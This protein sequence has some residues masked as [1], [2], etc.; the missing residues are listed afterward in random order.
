MKKDL[1]DYTDGR[2][3]IYHHDDPQS[4]SQYGDS[5]Q[6]TFM[7]FISGMAKGVEPKNFQPLVEQAW[8]LINKD[9]PRRHWD[10]TFWPGRPGFMSRDNLFPAVCALTIVDSKERFKLLWKII[11]RGG[12]LWNTRKI[13]QQDDSRKVPDWCGPL[14]FLIALKWVYIASIYLHLPIFFHLL[15]TKK[16]PEDTSDDLNLQIALV[17]LVLLGLKAKHIGALKYYF[18]NRPTI[19]GYFAKPGYCAALMQYFENPIAPPLDKVWLYALD[20]LEIP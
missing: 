15:K 20:S 6:R 4:G 18:N 9:E 10:E 5:C 8:A 17:T 13:G 1:K 7:Y 19:P 12:F 2:G 14:M 11:K 3:F 16:N